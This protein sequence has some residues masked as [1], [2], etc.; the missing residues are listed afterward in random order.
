MRRFSFLAILSALAF[1]PPAP[2]LAKPSAH[3]TQR[4]AAP[5][6]RLTAA[7]AHADLAIMREAL[8]VIHPGLYRRASKAEID[9][10]LRALEASIGK[11]GISDAELYRRIS[12]LLAMIRCSHTKADQTEAMEAWRTRHASHLPMRFRLIEGR[13]IVVSSDPGQTKLPRGAE[14]LAI[15]GRPVREL[16]ATLGAY[17]PID[18]RTEASRAAYLANDGDLMGADFDHFYPYAYGFPERFTVAFRNADDG[19]PR[20]VSLR[21]ISFRAWTKLANDGLSYRRDFGGSVSWKMAAS[22]VGYLRIDTFVN[23]RQ[24]VDA[25]ALYSRAIGELRAAGAEALVLDLREDGGGSNDA[26]LALID[27]LAA[28]P[29]TYQRAMRYRA[30]RYGFLPQY[31]S[32]WGDRDM[33]FNPALDRFT[34]SRDGRYDLRSENAPDELLPRQPS[35]Q[36]F[37]GR[38]IVLSGPANASGATMAIA[39]LRD[40]GRVTVVGEPGG[41]SADGPTAGT[42]F[43]VK[44]PNSGIAV[45]VP[46]VFNQ[47]AVERFGPDGG[48]SPD[49][50]V[51][52]TVADFRKGRDRALERA[53]AE[54][55]A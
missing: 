2:L 1:A 32:T 30:V 22:R 40:M 4:E 6:R 52:M 29:Y 43:S 13:M 42:I 39:K 36:R 51:A 31:I 16:V 25:A 14:V 18:G 34:Q 17:V 12:L 21:P 5:I 11:G 24:P 48:I 3:A 19:R 50:P 8:E 33:L 23:Y 26:A 35:A 27:A 20:T 41:G 9:G 55:G 10:A 46:L 44:L 28:G 49:V 45:R 15:N 53:I 37:E 7:Q 38:V 47:M 54:L